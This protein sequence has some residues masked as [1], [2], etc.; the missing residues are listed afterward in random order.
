MTAGL[1][2]LM[3][4]VGGAV[5]VVEAFCDSVDA[6]MTP[7]RQAA[8]RETHPELTFKT[9]NGDRYLDNKQSSEGQKQRRGT[10]LKNGF[11][12]IDSWLGELRGTGAKADDLFDACAAALAA[13]K[14]LKL[15]CAEE[16]DAR[17]LRME[18]WY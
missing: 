3:L 4:I 16:V 1:L 9:L 2:P 13:V 11:D 7:E 15:E 17:G 12:D 5:G 18:M 14:P 8:I 6:L 10:L